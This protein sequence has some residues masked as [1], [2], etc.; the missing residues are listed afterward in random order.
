M[1]EGPELEHELERV[2]ESAEESSEA[3]PSAEAFVRTVALS[4]ALIA[5]F[6]ALAALKAGGTINEAILLKSEA[7]SLSTQAFDAWAQYQAKG[8]RTS[9]LKAEKQLLISLDRV[10]PPS[11][12]DEMARYQ[13]EQNEI[14]TAAKQKE[15]Q[16]RRHS[17]EAEQLA[18]RHHR[19]AG[20]VTLLQIA[21]ALSAIAAL[22]RSR[23][24]WF[25]SLVTAGGGMV[26]YLDGFLRFC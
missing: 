6:A 13:K 8:V 24:I 19:F 21:V 4:T 3:R 10:P 11:L 23:A 16:S 12:D 5:V 22:A 17:E 25:L 14:F 18:H 1:P 9:V 2:R 26:F 20:A 7:M 15:E